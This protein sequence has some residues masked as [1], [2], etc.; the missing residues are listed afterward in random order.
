MSC[1]V[2][3]AAELLGVSEKTIRRRIQRGQLKAEKVARPGGFSYVVDIDEDTALPG[4]AA[5]DSVIHTLPALLEMIQERDAKI[6]QLSHQLGMYM[7]RAGNLEGQM[8]LLTSGQEEQP[9]KPW[10]RKVLRR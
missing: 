2:K 6:E 5:E 1:S 7:E 3:E 10:W 9:R 4:R 8:K